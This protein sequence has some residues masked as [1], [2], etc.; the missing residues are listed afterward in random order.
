MAIA[1][2]VMVSVVEEYDPDRYASRPWE[3]GDYREAAS[4]GGNGAVS[5]TGALEMAEIDGVSM[6]HAKDVGRGIITYRS[7]AVE[8]V[9]V[10]K[11]KVDVFLLIGQSN[12]N[13]RPST[14][15]AATVDP[16]PFPGTAYYYGTAES[17]SQWDDPSLNAFMDFALPDGSS[18]LG[19]KMPVIAATYHEE[20]GRKMLLIDSAIGG[21][22]IITF[23]P[24]D[25]DNWVRATTAVTT[26]MAAL[27]ASEYFEAT[28]TYAYMFIQGESDGTHS[29]TKA[30]YMERFMKMH[31]AIL[32]GGLGAEFHHCFI[33]LTHK[34]TTSLAQSQLAEDHPDTITVASS[35]ALTFTVENGLMN[36]DT[37]HYTQAG[38]NIIGKDLGSAC[39]GYVEEAHQSTLSLLIHAIPAVLAAAGIAA[40]A[41]YIIQFRQRYRKWK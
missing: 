3:Y 30:A 26:T 33:S 10:G 41:V 29:T 17:C 38:D 35:A 32:A 22:R 18:R 37:Y 31:D 25:G 4:L 2:A 11:A 5:A 19:D 15:D 20:T 24:P 7:G 27:E 6:V 39:A 28:G 8:S 1:L 14:A 21:T 36:E 13:Y 34:G 16:K 40:I 12:A 23:V 9:E